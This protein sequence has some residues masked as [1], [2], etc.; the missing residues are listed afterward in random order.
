MV[1]LNYA[2]WSIK[3][4]LKYLKKH[5]RMFPD[6]PEKERRLEQVKELE[7]QLGDIENG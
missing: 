4:E 2:L 1:V 7:K 5:I 6:S 3:L